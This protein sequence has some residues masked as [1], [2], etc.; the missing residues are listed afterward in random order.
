MDL[1]VIPD[2]L[3]P[4]IEDIVK[5]RVDPAGQY[6]GVTLRQIS[7][8]IHS[9]ARQDVAA[10][11]SEF[12]YER[13]GEMYDPVL[14]NFIMGSGGQ[15]STWDRVADSK[16]AIVLRGITKRKE[17]TACREQGRDFYY[18]DTGYFGNGKKKLYHR[19]TKNDVQYLGPVRER[20]SDRLEAAGYKPRKFRSGKNIL[21]APPSQKLLNL[22]NINLDQWLE[23]T[24]EEIKKYSD[25]PIVMRLKQPRSV[26]VNEDTI[27]MALEQDVHCLVTFSSIA[28]T[29]SVLYGKPAITLGP[30]AAAPMC[31]HSL[32]EIENPKIPSLEEVYA[33][34]KNLAYCQFTEEEM[35]NGKAWKILNE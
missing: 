8:Q 28:A 3:R 33:W 2:W 14:T 29:E 12:R 17:M 19:V 20:S 9:L 32:A 18:I 16:C 24:V 34:A 6:H 35:R 4:I 5:Y 22:Y 10:I 1:S 25:R 7:A 26:R 21:L 11:D 30:N 23:E 13:K 31:S 27:E 15:L